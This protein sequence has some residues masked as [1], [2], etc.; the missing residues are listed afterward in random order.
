MGYRATFTTQEPVIGASLDCNGQPGWFAARQ[1]LKL[2]D[3]AR[4][5]PSTILEAGGTL[6]NAPAFSAPL[7]K[8]IMW[9]A[10][11]QPGLTAAL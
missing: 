2:R 3:V 6:E 7:S 9:R 8:A 4:F 5:C 10:S 11:Y 1:V